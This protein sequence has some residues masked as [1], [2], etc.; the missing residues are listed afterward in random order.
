VTIRPWFTILR[1]GSAAPKVRYNIH[2]LGGMVAL[3]RVCE[4]LR[5]HGLSLDGLARRRSGFPV[6]YMHG[7]S[8]LTV[9]FYGAKVFTTDIEAVLSG[10]PALRQA[11]RSFQMRSD[12][13]ERLDEILTIA[14]E[15]APGRP[16]PLDDDSLSGLFYDGLKRVNQDFREVSRLFGPEKLHIQQH[17]AE[18]GPFAQRDLRVKNQYVA[19][20]G[21]VGATA[22]ALRGA[23]PYRSAPTGR[24]SAAPR[25]P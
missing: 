17:D 7:R 5:H 1:R 11:F 14:L 18:S 4:V 19:P 10:H 15:R 9:P 22:E 8:D 20:A 25:P 12:P 3:R 21:G 16:Q 13:D 23:G 24:R 2:D 6:L